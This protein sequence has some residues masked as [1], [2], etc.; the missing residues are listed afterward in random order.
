[1]PIL[2]AA[3]PYFNQMLPN[4]RSY[5]NKTIPFIHP[6]TA[7]TLSFYSPQYRASEA[8]QW[9]LVPKYKTAVNQRLCSLAIRSSPH[10][11][12]QKLHHTSTPSHLCDLR[13]TCRLN[14][15]G[16]SFSLAW[17]ASHWPLHSQWQQWQRTHP[18]LAI[19][20]WRA[21]QNP[22]QAAAGTV[23]KTTWVVISSGQ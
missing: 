16:P 8:L 1:M 3:A 17:Q 11:Q 10:K 5:Q 4:Q 18:S 22:S 14:S 6:A 19:P 13:E 7:V 23:S 15:S 20:T 2:L 9:V 12:F 21:K